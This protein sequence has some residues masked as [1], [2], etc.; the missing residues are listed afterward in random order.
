MLAQGASGK[1]EMVWGR[2]RCSTFGVAASDDERYKLNRHRAN[3]WYDIFRF[4]VMPSQVAPHRS[5]YFKRRLHL[6]KL[7]SRTIPA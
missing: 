4:N 1:V 3:Y 7:A 5:F 2:H 6:W